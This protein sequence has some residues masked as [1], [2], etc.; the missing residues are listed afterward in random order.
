MKKMLTAAAAAALLSAP[1]AQAEPVKLNMPSTFPGSLIQLGEAGVKLQDTLNLISGGE[2]EVKFFEPN[3]LVPPLEI[4]D[5]VSNG[6][7]DAGWSVPGYWGSKNSALN[8]FAAVP[9]GPS[10]GEYLA[11]MWYGGGEDM[12]NEIYNANGIHSLVCGIIAPEASGWFREEITGPEDLAGLKM[13][14]FGLGA[15]VMQKLGVDTQLLA[16]GDIYPALERGTIDATEFSMPA[17]DLNLG[18]YNIAKHYYF[19]GWHQQSTIQELLISKAKWDGMTDQQRGLITTACR[20][21]VATQFAEGEAIQSAALK[22]IEGNGVTI[23]QWDDSMLDTLRSA[24]EE[25]V[26]EEVAANPDFD[27][28]WTSL[29]EF[30]EQYTTW[31]E[32]GYLK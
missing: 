7:V 13:R 23:H 26:A 21:N 2:V 8:L 32:L 12:M 15:K 30:R 10:A 25:V 22:E 24:W 17:I 20:A 18:F 9:F 5:A 19:P 14:F 1:M 6:S 31:K 4:F 3:A 27:K 28:A 11:W 16:G 29:S